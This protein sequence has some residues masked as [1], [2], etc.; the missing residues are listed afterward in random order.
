[1]RTAPVLALAV[2]VTAV[3]PAV[4]AEQ[5]VPPWFDWVK[6]NPEAVKWVTTNSSVVNWTP[7]CE[8]WVCAAK[9]ILYVFPK[10]HPTRNVDYREACREVYDAWCGSNAALDELKKTD[11]KTLPMFGRVNWST[12]GVTEGTFYEWVKSGRQYG[13][14]YA[15]DWKPWRDSELM[16]AA[17][18]IAYW[19]ASWIPYRYYCGYLNGGKPEAILENPDKD[20][21]WNCC[22][23][24]AL[25]VA[26]MRAAGIP[27][28]PVLGGPSGNDHTWVEVYNVDGNWV[29]VDPTGNAGNGYCKPYW[30]S[31]WISQNPYEPGEQHYAI[32][33][34][35]IENAWKSLYSNPNPPNPNPLSPNPIA[36]LT[37]IALV[38]TVRKLGR[39]TT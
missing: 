8:N 27:A 38:G 2:V 19:V 25:A 3:T 15:C 28:K 32:D 7:H 39:R 26:L 35:R 14:R 22:D 24:A 9:Y 12:N 17:I 18:R 37:I 23:H 21:G 31:G 33:V 5:G 6:S 20:G 36:I 11:V 29:P 10:K 4:A 13:Q 34:N 1:M 30:R 16:R